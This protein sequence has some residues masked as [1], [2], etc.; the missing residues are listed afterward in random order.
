MKD[1]TY[2]QCEDQHHFLN[3]KKNNN[4]QIISIDKKQK[5]VNQKLQLP[6]KKLKMSQAVNILAPR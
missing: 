4:T 5:H 1:L 3:I 6:V 2:E